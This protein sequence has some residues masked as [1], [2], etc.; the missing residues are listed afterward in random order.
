MATHAHPHVCTPPGNALQLISPLG[1]AAAGRGADGLEFGCA[2]DAACMEELDK[3]RAVNGGVKCDAPLPL[4]SVLAPAVAVAAIDCRSVTAAE[5][6]R[7]APAVDRTC[8]T[9][10]VRL[11]ASSTA[12]AA[13]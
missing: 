3:L 4:A 11:A 9:L 12:T 6:R 1:T 13:T 5:L 7:L 8:F 2:A 10:P